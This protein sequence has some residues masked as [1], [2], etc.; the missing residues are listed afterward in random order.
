MHKIAIPQSAID[1]VLKRR[2]ALHVFNDLDRPAPPVS[3]L[4][5]LCALFGRS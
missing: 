5:E 2:D 3:V 1:R 4:N